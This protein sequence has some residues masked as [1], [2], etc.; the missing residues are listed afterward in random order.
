[1]KR[2]KKKLPHYVERNRKKKH[3]ADGSTTEVTQESRRENICRIFREIIDNIVES[4][5][6]KIITYVKISSKFNFFSNLENL[7]DSEIKNA[8]D[9][10][11]KAYPE[12][13]ESYPYKE[14][15]QFSYL[16]NKKCSGINVAER[17]LDV[18]VFKKD[19]A[20]V[21]PNIEIAQRIYL[22]LM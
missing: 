8:A 22:S 6:N 3:L 2:S 18:S 19:W 10:L 14:L 5:E 21:F 16:L 13:L 17:Y 15:V 20:S 9:G 7:T 1:M 12:D 4:L 11:Q